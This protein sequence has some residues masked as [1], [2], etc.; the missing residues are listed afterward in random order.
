MYIL[1]IVFFR[2]IILNDHKIVNLLYKINMNNNISNTLSQFIKTK[3]YESNL[4]NSEILSF[5]EIVQ[6]TYKGLI[7]YCDTVYEDIKFLKNQSEIIYIVSKNLSLFLN[8]LKKNNEELKLFEDMVI[9]EYTLGRHAAN[10]GIYSGFFGD[11][12]KETQFVEL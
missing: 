4:L 8:C 12:Y 9:R 2:I 1:I 5:K 10:V 3:D 11:A 6:T 7:Q